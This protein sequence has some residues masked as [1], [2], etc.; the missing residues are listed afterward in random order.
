MDLAQILNDPVPVSVTNPPK[1]GFPHFKELPLELRIAIWEYLIPD[2]RIIWVKPRILGRNLDSQGNVQ[3]VLGPDSWKIRGWKT[4][5]DYIKNHQF[6]QEDGSPCEETKGNTWGL[7]TDISIPTLLHVCKE[8][9]D[10]ASRFYTETLPWRDNLRLGRILIS[11]ETQYIYI[12][13][14]SNSGKLLGYLQ[15]VCV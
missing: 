14:P 8:S 7:E 9:C 1:E 10:I 15:L 6:L 11:R 4:A 13:G 12:H 3:P 5:R 2:G